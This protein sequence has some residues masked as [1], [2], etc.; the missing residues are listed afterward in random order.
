MDD[1]DDESIGV[2]GIDSA[3]DDRWGQ[4][5]EAYRVERG[6]DPGARWQ[7][8]LYIGTSD[9]ELWTW[10]EPRLDY[11]GHGALLDL[12]DARD[13]PSGAYLDA[14]RELLVA[15]ARNL[16]NP[17]RYELGR[18]LV[19]GDYVSIGMG[20]IVAQ[21][22][23]TN[24]LVVVRALRVYHEAARVLGVEPPPDAEEGDAEEG[25]VGEDD[26]AFRTVWVQL[27]RNEGD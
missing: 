12:G 16:F 22:E 18:Y 21:L 1:F 6:E 7:A 3:H 2:N 20:K 24:F 4:A 25:L 14:Q 15:V 10:L 5:M 17:E 13:E 9:A 11:E 19:N 23:H 27:D 8:L 26:G